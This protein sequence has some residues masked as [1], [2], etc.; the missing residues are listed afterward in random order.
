[1]I[2][3]PLLGGTV[4]LDFTFRPQVIKFSFKAKFKY[5]EYNFNAF[6]PL[7]ERQRRTAE[8]MV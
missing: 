8:D 5:F 2:E 4:G 3:F 7:G 1:M 6:L